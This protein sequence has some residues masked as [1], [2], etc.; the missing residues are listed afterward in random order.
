M[1]DFAVNPRRLALV[2]VDL[3]N[4]F[5]VGFPISSP[6]GPAVVAWINRLAAAC[7]RA[8]V[9]VVHTAHVTRADGSNVGVMGEIIPS[10]REGMIAK[11]SFPAALHKELK[12]VPGDVVLEK[13][14][15]GAFHG[16]DLELIL[17]SRGIDS[18]IVSGIA[19][20]VCAETTAREASV[21][22]FRVFF[23]SDGTA[24]MDMGG[25]SRD[26]LQ[27][28]T[29]TVLG[30]AFAQVLTIDQMTERLKTAGQSPSRS[31]A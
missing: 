7:R 4:V 15:F 16:T 21:C 23:L 17:R 30:F 6:D 10:V 13:P 11:G 28:A 29:C 5:V 27:R 20:N 18:V 24:T 1:V 3:Q 9:L 22:D 14:R 26:V 25:V 31:E 19:T 12:V 2:N 8:G